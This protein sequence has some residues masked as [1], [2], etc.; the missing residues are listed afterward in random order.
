MNTE[1]RYW[2]KKRSTARRRQSAQLTQSLILREAER[3]FI[4]SGYDLTSVS[5]I[6]QAL[7]MSPANI[8]KHFGTKGQLASKVIEN[9]LSAD[10]EVVG[11][12]RADRLESL[13]MQISNVILSISSKEPK[14]AEVVKR[15]LTSAETCEALRRHLEQRVYLVLT[16]GYPPGFETAV[17]DVFV[18]TLQSFSV[19]GGEVLLRRRIQSYIVLLRAAL[20]GSRRSSE[21]QSDRAD[22]DLLNKSCC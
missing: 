18:A 6:A 16:C 21:N 5:G 22:R 19:E 3:S 17:A 11:E 4:E 2:V 14:L 8:F 10:I 15:F 9:R 13:L 20:S 1:A 12:A 7:N